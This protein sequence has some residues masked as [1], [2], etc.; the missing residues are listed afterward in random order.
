MTK[1][2]HFK[3]PVEATVLSDA[4]FDTQN[5]QKLQETGVSLG[6]SRVRN[7]LMSGVAQA[8]KQNIMSN[9]KAQLAEEESKKAG[10]RLTSKNEGSKLGE[11]TNPEF[12]EIDEN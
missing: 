5:N 4:D 7:R 3:V 9:F 2:D 10:Q 8:R 11:N 12:G 1:S 6:N